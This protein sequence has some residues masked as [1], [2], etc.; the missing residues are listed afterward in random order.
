MNA[1]PSRHKRTHTVSLNPLETILTAFAAT[2]A[3]KGLT[4]TLSSLDATPT[5]Y[6]GVSLE[7]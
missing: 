2:I 5:K 4:G 7:S 6:E 1:C 3:N